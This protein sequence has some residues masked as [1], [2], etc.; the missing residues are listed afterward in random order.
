MKNLNNKDKALTR[1]EMQ[2]EVKKLQKYGK[3]IVFTNGC[4]D[5]LH[6]GHINLLKKAKSLGDIL[7]VAI[8]SDKSL[9]CL[10]GNKRPLVGEKDRAKLLLSL[11]V[12]DYVVVFGEQTPK[13]ILRE[14]RPDI[15]I[16][17]GDYKL[18]EIVGKEYVKKVY[19]F[20]VVK[21]KSTTNLINLIVERYGFKQKSRSSK[22]IMQ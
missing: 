8:N 20:P 2:A 15:L 14:L 22:K 3:R 5:L 1:K 12:V 6:L 13:E 4:F 16:K 10:K 17:G 18:S 21:N 7:I 11:R 9:S 19:R